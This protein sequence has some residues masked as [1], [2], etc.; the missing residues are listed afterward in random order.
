M[1]IFV[2][3]FTVR[4]DTATTIGK[5]VFIFSADSVNTETRSNIKCGNKLSAG[6]F[7]LAAAIIPATPEK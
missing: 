4:I 2:E 3:E 5:L 6:N 7:Y 1:N